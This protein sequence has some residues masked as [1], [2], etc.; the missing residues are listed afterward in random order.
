MT[1][2]SFQ[3]QT[4][5]YSDYNAPNDAKYFPSYQKRSHEYRTNSETNSDDSRDHDREGQYAEVIF[6][7]HV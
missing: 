7:V 3:H 4:P 1:M 6:R 2:S 5:T